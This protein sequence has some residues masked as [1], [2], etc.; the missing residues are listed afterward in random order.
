[1]APEAT[2]APASAAAFIKGDW[3]QSRFIDVPHVDNLMTALVGLGGEHWAL[4]RRM[5]VIESLLAR[6]GTLRAAD[7]EAYEPTAA[8]AQAWAAERDDFIR[9][10]FG[11]LTREVADVAGAIDPQG[12]RLVPPRTAGSAS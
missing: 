4:R 5:L 1:M 8:E 12:E 6:T 10:V 2:S 11:V 9:R 7:I 3:D